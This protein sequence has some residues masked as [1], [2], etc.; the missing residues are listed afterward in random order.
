MKDLA[1]ELTPTKTHS[2]KS[3][4]DKVLHIIKKNGER[5]EKNHIYQGTGWDAE[6]SMKILEIMMYQDLIVLE[7]RWYKGKKIPG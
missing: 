3:D 6:A 7:E 5:A 2:D 4:H 1:I